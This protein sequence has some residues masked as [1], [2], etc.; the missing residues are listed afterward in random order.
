VEPQCGQ[1]YFYLAA[2]SN[3][4]FS[5]DAEAA[6]ADEQEAEEDN[7]I[8]HRMRPDS[9]GIAVGQMVSEE[10]DGHLC[11][12]EKADGA[13]EEAQDEQ[14]SAEEFYTGADEAEDDRVER[15]IGHATDGFPH[16]RAAEEFGISVE[17]ERRPQTE[18][19]KKK[20]KIS[21]PR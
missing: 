14:Y 16:V 1:G 17:D 2:L 3:G 9:I 5:I 11:G 12:Q 6:W 21:K 7:A 4:L 8:F 15:D 10:S 18:A 19:E 13:E 20:P